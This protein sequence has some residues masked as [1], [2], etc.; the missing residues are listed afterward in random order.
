MSRRV[1]RRP[2]DLKLT[3]TRNLSAQ[4]NN[5]EWLLSMPGTDEQK[6]FLLDCN[7]CHTYQRIVNST[8]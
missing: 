7:G 4:L 5:A 6:K 3:K 2:A 8:L 1:K